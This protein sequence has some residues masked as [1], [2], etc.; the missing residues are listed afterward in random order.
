MIDA[1]DDFDDVLL[2]PR[3]A[4]T[5]AISHS[6][7]KP[8]VIADAQDNAGAGASSDT[9]GLLSALV[10]S[11]AQGVILAILNDVEV[12][13][14]AHDLGKNAEFSASLGGKVRAGRPAPL[15][16]EISC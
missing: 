6:G 7:P 12:A 14:Q 13:A 9:T 15:R 8:V 1:E 5:E 4:I 10:E 3:S 16:G 2:S 11:D